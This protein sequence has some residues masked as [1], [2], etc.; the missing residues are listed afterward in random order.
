MEVLVVDNF[1][2]FTYMLVDYLRQAGA[3]CR[4]I[5]NDESMSC[6]T[7]DSVDAVVLS[8]GP[9]VPKA[10]NRLMDIIDYYHRRVPM[11]GVC[12][13]HQALGEFFGATLSRAGKPMHG[14]VSTVRVIEKDCLWQGV[15][16]TFDVTRYHSLVLTDL[17]VEL[18]STAV[19]EENELMAMRHRTLPLWGVQFHPEAAL[20]QYGLTL[21]QNWIDALR[22][23]HKRNDLTTPLTAQYA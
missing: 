2:S 18:V 3:D 10:A 16:A 22:L 13:G 6:L 11:L 21:I 4:V 23:I 7:R 9:G 14:K 20:T 19:T 15:P 8:P 5:R 1:D 12:L 17:P